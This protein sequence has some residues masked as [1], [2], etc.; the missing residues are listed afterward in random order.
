MLHGIPTSRQVV[1]R[2]EGVDGGR[3]AE[4]AALAAA[5]VPPQAGGIVRGAPERSAMEVSAASSRQPSTVPV[6][7]IIAVGERVGTLDGSDPILRG[8]Q[9]LPA[10]RGSHGLT[11][12][13]ETADFLF[14]SKLSK[15]SSVP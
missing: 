11:L 1:N 13:K 12:C 6:V 2:E 7:W 10:G 15:N 14:T 9:G 3:A 5:G 8:A 4:S